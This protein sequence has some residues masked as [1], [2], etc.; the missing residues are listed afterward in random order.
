MMEE[1]NDGVKAKDNSKYSYINKNKFQ[2]LKKLRI[3]TILS[4]EGLR[5]EKLGILLKKW[6][7]GEAFIMEYKEKT[8]NCRRIRWRKLR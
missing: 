2:L 6:C 7:N 5:R 8:G 1:V 4:V 3:R